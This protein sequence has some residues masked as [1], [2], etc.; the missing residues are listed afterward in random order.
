M[1][2]IKFWFSLRIDNATWG[3]VFFIIDIIT[4]KDIQ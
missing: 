2:S 4:L 1:E 3:R